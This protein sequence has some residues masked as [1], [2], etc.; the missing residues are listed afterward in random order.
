M[1][2]PM[3][4]KNPAAGVLQYADRKFIWY[5]CLSFNSLETNFVAG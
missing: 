1:S 2:D 5:F 3:E 4:N